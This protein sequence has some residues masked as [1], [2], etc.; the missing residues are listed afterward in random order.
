MSNNSLPAPGTNPTFSQISLKFQ[1]RISRIVFASK[2]L[3]EGQLFAGHM[4]SSPSMKRK[5]KNTS[6]D[7][8]KC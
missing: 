6:N 8:E 4:V 2:H 1:V 5:G 7:N 3:F